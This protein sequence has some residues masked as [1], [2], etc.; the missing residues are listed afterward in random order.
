MSETKQPH[1]AKGTQS[2]KAAPKPASAPDSSQTLKD[3]VFAEQ[4]RPV[5]SVQRDNQ[6]L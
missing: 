2:D 6:L 5:A 3:Q 4:A 1:D